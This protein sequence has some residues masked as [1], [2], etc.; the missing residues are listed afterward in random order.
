MTRASAIPSITIVAAMS[1]NRAIGR[2]GD[3]PWR[4]NGDFKF[5]QDISRNK[6]VI[7][8]RKTYVG[9]PP[10]FKKR[11]KIIVVTRD[12]EFS[13]DGVDVVHSIE[14]AV[15]RARKIAAG[16]TC[17][18]II[19]GGGAEI[20]RQAFDHADHMYLSEIHTTVP[21]GDA[22]FPEFD[23]SA[24]NTVLDETYDQKPGDTCG[25]TLRH[26]VRKPAEAVTSG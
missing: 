25:F 13:A 12:T 22:F 19:I 10:S 26:Y 14:D 3:I 11:D 9:M 5:W 8:G 4:V 18:D 6:P 20:Y 1:E 2:N 24:W 7:M 15:K 17:H 23:E 21:D 16:H